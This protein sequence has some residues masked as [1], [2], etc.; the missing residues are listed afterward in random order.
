MKLFSEKENA[1][2]L[3]KDER[4]E[5]GVPCHLFHFTPG[6]LVSDLF[7][8]IR[9]ALTWLAKTDSSIKFLNLS[10]ATFCFIRT[11]NQTY[12]DEYKNNFSSIVGSTVST[13]D[14]P[15]VDDQC[16][17][18]DR[19]A[20]N[21]GE[22][23]FVRDDGVIMVGLWLDDRKGSFKYTTVDKFVELVEKFTNDS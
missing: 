9:L 16:R 22:I 7:P 3:F 12:A 6:A 5:D 21:E 17:W 15:T 1:F 23:Y 2:Y 8:C 20:E 10:G 13:T 18:M 11:R 4:L 14:K 19:F